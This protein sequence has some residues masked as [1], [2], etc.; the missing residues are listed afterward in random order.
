MAMELEGGVLAVLFFPSH[1]HPLPAESDRS[2][3][4]EN[5]NYGI[6]RVR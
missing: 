2:E 3:D 1:S 4:G 5:D 6:D